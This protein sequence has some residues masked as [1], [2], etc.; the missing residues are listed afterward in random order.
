MA[1][2]KAAKKK[3]PSAKKAGKKKKAPAKKVVGE[4]RSYCNLPS[5]APRSFGPNIGVDRQRLILMSDQK[6]A[7]GTKLRYYFFNKPTDGQS[8]VF[9]DGTTG[10]IPWVGSSAERQLVKDAFKVWK[11]VGIGLEFEEVA[12]REDAQ[13]RIG[14]MKGDGHWSYVGRQ[15]LGQ[16]VNA[17]TMN[18]GQ[19]LP[20][21]ENGID[22]AIH[23]IGHT[24]GF[25]H[26]HQNPNAGIVWNEQAVINDLAQ[27]PNEWDEATTRHNILNKIA[28]DSVQ[29]SS[30]DPDSIM[31]YPF[32]AGMIVSPPQYSGGLEP[33]GGLSPRDIA[34]VKTFYPELRDADVTDLR[35]FES[36]QL[37]LAP[38][39]QA[40]F[41]IQPQETRYYDIQT[42]GE[43]DTNA[44]LFE[45]DGDEFRYLTADDSSGEDR[46]SSL[47]VKLFRDH[48]YM[49][50][51]RLYFA[52]Q[53]GN[54]AVMMW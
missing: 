42:F 23:E 26:E 24:L 20:F 18:F 31:H 19:N 3:S 46:G 47:R 44:V 39:E 8:V 29:G 12:N 27:P 25:P 16:G 2:K 54:V 50:R 38:G 34:W 15:I 28:P 33:A 36:S 32:K 43:S 7:N 17:R 11:D 49:L 21:I 35:P 1:K 52:Q 6:W 30:W 37:K 13:I 45:K 14:F 9:Q 41:R 40:N 22:T 4:K 10:F 51:L 53:V 48:S 5:V